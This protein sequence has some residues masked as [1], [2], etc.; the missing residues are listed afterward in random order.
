MKIT[1]ER[2]PV[3]IAVLNLKQFMKDYCKDT[4]MKKS[5]IKNIRYVENQIKD[6]EST[7]FIY[8][9]MDWLSIFKF[10]NETNQ[11]E[12]EINIFKC[13]MKGF[14]KYYPGLLDPE[15]SLV[16]LEEERIDKVD[17]LVTNSFNRQLEPHLEMMLLANLIDHVNNDWK[18][19]IRLE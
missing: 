8:H 13:D 1:I 14:I 7:E 2:R 12:I 11:D 6:K 18:K 17:F 15:Q 19:V 9:S 16:T 10:I 4:D 5:L 3:S